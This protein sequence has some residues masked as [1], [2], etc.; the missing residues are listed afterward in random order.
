MAT[1]KPLKK[2]PTS[3]FLQRKQENYAQLQEQQSPR[4]ARALDDELSAL[5]TPVKLKRMSTGEH[6]ILRG[7]AACGQVRASPHHCCRRT[8]FTRPSR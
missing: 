3:R 2:P 4:T 6:I 8:A 7:V 5:T 1:V